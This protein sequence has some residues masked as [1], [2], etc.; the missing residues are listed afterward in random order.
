MAKA[1]TALVDRALRSVAHAAGEGIYLAQTAWRNHLFSEKYRRRIAQEHGRCCAGYAPPHEAL[2]AARRFLASN[3]HGYSDLR[4]HE[5]YWRVSGMVDSAYIPEDIF[6]REIEPALNAMDY[7][8]VLTDKN[9][10][11][12]APVAPYLPEPVVH[13][14]RG[15]LYRPGFVRIG[16][17]EIDTLLAT[18][19]DEFIVKPSTEHGGGRSLRMM[20]GPS[21]ADFLRKELRER[22]CGRCTDWTVQRRFEQCAAMAQFNPS[23]VNTYR[24]MTLRIDCDI[25]CIS[26]LLRMGRSG[27]RVDNHAAGGV[28]C[29]IDGGR[30][31]GRGIDRDYR[32][33]AAHPDNGT[34]LDGEPPAYEEAVELCRELHRTMPWFDLISWDVAIDARQQPRIIEFNL[35]SQSI[36]IHQLTNGPLFGPEGSALLAAVLRRMTQAGQERR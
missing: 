18:S 24:V 7:V 36:E 15:E 29:G 33:Y 17:N 16:E 1:T 5:L 25:Q 28:I 22:H 19:R 32:I 6:Y 9:E 2:E 11:Y 20:D 13:V 12:N 23:S 27:M 34:P 21:A 14:I 26:G 31:R 4:W 10:C 3:F 30:L 35:Q 8:H